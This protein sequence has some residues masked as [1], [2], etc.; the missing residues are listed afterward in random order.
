MQINEQ[1]LAGKEWRLKSVD[2]TPDM[3]ANPERALAHHCNFGFLTDE[4]PLSISILV[5]A[6]WHGRREG[7]MSLGFE[8][9]CDVSLLESQYMTPTKSGIDVWTGLQESPLNVVG[10]HGEPNGLHHHH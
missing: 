7:R 1:H 8:I 5:I 2:L 9:C 6:I 10:A 4:K 3:S